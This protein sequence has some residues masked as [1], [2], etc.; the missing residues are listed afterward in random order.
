MGRCMHFLAH[1]SG[2]NR[3]Q[4]QMVAIC[5]NIWKD[6]RGKSMNDGDGY[7][8]GAPP[9]NDGESQDDYVDRCA[10]AMRRH[11]SC[12]N[13]SDE[14]CRSM[15]ELSYQRNGSASFRGRLNQKGLNSTGESNASARISAGDVDKDSSWSFSADDGNKLL[16]P[17]GDNWSNYARWFLGTHEGTD[18]HTKDHYGYPFG[19]NGKVYASA[20]R[21]IRSRASQ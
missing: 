18:E 4:D 1:E 10:Q 16:G 15:C 9:V 17:N 6:E 11:P 2:T 12:G 3:P 21:A 5:M 7:G 19:K 20:L 8:L 14:E 13:M